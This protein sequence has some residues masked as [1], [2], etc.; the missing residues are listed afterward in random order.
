MGKCLH[1]TGTQHRVCKAGI[2]YA[3]LKATG[4]FPCLAHFNEAGATCAQRV[5]PT[6]AAAR[7]LIEE[8]DRYTADA[9][10]ALVACDK[11]AAGRCPHQGTVTC[12]RCD[13]TLRYSIAGNR[14]SA[15]KCDTPNC[16]AWIS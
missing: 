4:G 9:L 1:F 11:D 7:A 14:H 3:D 12:P 15:G 8:D 6:E 2:A 10:A 16:L 5:L 13:G